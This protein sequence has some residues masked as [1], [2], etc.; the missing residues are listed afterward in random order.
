MKKTLI[1]LDVSLSSLVT[2][3]ILPSISLLLILPFSGSTNT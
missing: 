3:R 1:Q 2:F